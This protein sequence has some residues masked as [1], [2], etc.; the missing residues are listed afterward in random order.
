ML[1][2]IVMRRRSSS[3]GKGMFLMG[4]LPLSLRPGGLELMEENVCEECGKQA[5][6]ALI[7]RRIATKSNNRWHKVMDACLYAWNLQKVHEPGSPASC[8][9][10]QPQ[11]SFAV[12]N[13]TLRYHPHHY[14]STIDHTLKPHTMCHQVSQVFECGHNNGSK[15]FPCTN[16]SDCGEEIFLR[17]ELEDMKG[18]CA[19]RY[20]LVSG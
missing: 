8:I 5:I 19:V 1:G 2:E 20:S 17:Q 10:L 7:H 14:I 12:S 11:V 4:E 13:N 18:L 9:C 3:L 6:A 16:P 15:K